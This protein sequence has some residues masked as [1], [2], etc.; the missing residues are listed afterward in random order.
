MEGVFIL[1]FW[2]WKVSYWFLLNAFHF[3]TAALSWTSLSFLLC[4]W[5]GR[6]SK[7][8]EG[9]HG[10]E[11]HLGLGFWAATCKQY[12]SRHTTS[13]TKPNISLLHL[14]KRSY[15]WAYILQGD[16]HCLYCHSQ[17]SLTRDILHIAL[18]LIINASKRTSKYD[19]K[20]SWI[21][22]L[23]TNAFFTFFNNCYGD[24]LVCRQ[25][26]KGEN[27]NLIGTH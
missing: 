19:A 6:I 5:Y 13:S 12:P 22:S 18:H 2:I 25:L 14:M 1:D 17:I 16:K 24:N 7:G 27:G 4:G 23:Q 8:V 15:F 3:E 21:W 10:E 11:G 26:G 20:F 9:I